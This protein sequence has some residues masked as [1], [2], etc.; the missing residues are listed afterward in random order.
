MRRKTWM[1]EYILQLLLALFAMVI[2]FACD[3]LLDRFYYGSPFR[4]LALCSILAG[5]IAGYY[6]TRLRQQRSSVFVWIPGLVWFLYTALSLAKMWNPAWAPSSRIAY[7]WDSLFGPS[8][9]SQECVYTIPTDVFLGSLAYSI[10]ARLALTKLP[11]PR[12]A[13][14]RT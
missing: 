10:A 2:G 11:K 3:M 7:V 13:A 9:T 5:G 1:V 8:C 4:Q 14:E 12:G 6:V